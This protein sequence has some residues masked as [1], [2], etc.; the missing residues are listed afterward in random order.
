[1]RVQIPIN[2]KSARDDIGVETCYTCKFIK[3]IVSAA[4]DRWPEIARD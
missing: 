4:F 1:M 3:A 2:F